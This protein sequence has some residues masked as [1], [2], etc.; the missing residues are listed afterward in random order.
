MKIVEIFHRRQVNEIS[1]SGL[2]AGAKKV[3][4]AVAG[5]AKDVGKQMVQNIVN[6]QDPNKS[7]S[8]P[9]DYTKDPAEKALAFAGKM[10]P[11]VSQGL[12]SAW[13]QSVHTLL[14]QSVNKKIGKKPAVSMGDIDINKL[15]KAMYNQLS[16][17]MIQA[18]GGRIDDFNKAD[19]QVQDPQTKTSINRAKINIEKQIGLIVAT[20][21]YQKANANKLNAAW[22]Q[23]AGN[24]LQIATLM[25]FEP[26]TDKTAANKRIQFNP[27]T[28]KWMIDGRTEFNPTNPQHL[29]IARAEGS[30]P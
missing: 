18:T 21:L 23:V 8:T 1:M 11:K 13:A 15:E 5:V 27:T 26:G 22:N 6:P 19:Q 10:V 16:A 2:M 14:G 25:K 3:G 12:Q 20:D 30:A 29:D 24:L 17:F 9:V 7:T 4:G 28:K